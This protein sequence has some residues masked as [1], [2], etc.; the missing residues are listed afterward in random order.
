MSSR[1]KLEAS[2]RSTNA[3]TWDRVADWYDRLVG[4]EGSDYHRN[5]ILPAA[6]ELLAVKKGERVLDVCCGQ[7]VFARALVEAGA[8]EVVG[9]DASAKL[10]AAA[11]ARA[12]ASSRCRFLVGDVR[13]LA[14]VLGASHPG[15]RPANTGHARPPDPP[16]LFDSAACL[17][18]V[19]DLEDVR[20]GFD[21]VASCLK[22]NGRLVVIL[23]HPCF[24]I[25]RQSSWSWDEEHKIQYRRV[26]RYLTPMTIP[27]AIAPRGGERTQTPFFHRPLSQ[28]LNALGEAGLPIV[29]CEEIVSHHSV[30]PGG[31]SRGENRSFREFP[32]F[33]ALLCRKSASPDHA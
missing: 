16:R 23:M 31:R 27:I 9:V 26:D 2:S 6:L 7:G 3:S 25:P 10:I 29:R 11:K 14:E 12:G 13:R 5:V 18:A 21:G 1:R 17:M 15:A 30:Q 33:L 19:Q 4:D 22:P 28:I 32:I 24:R 20:A 8:G